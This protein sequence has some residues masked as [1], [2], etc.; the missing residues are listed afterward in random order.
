[1]FIRRLMLEFAT[2]RDKRW[3]TQ[4]TNQQWIPRTL[5][6]KP[7]LSWVLVQI[8]CVI[9]WHT[10]LP[11]QTCQKRSNGAP[12]IVRKEKKNLF[13]KDQ[14]QL[15]H[16]E[17]YSKFDITLLYSL[18]RNICPITPHVNGWG[19]DPCPADRSVSANIERIRLKRNE[20]GHSSKPYITE[21][22]F[23]KTF[24][25]ISQITQE[26]EHYLG[27]TSKYHDAVQEIETCTM[28]PE[29]SEKYI[30]KLLNI[31]EKLHDISGS[32]YFY[33]WEMGNWCNGENHLS[34]NVQT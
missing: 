12:R 3:L 2:E 24:Q 29:E 5:P 10:K 32:L 13:T 16:G 31:N 17:N 28:D 6:V 15:I 18:L 14:L 19:N 27:T 1:M 4:N 25:E 20:Y 23:K 11:L 34:L 21:K 26:L 8:Y 7:E 33:Q 9:Y 30:E 22:E